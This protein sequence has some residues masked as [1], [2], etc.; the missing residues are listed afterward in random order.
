MSEVVTTNT[1]DEKLNELIEYMGSAVPSKLNELNSKI[2]SI[3]S[4]WKEATITGKEVQAQLLNSIKPQSGKVVI[5]GIEY[6]NFKALH[7]KLDEKVSQVS[8]ILD[9]KIDSVVNVSSDQAVGGVKTFSSPP[10]SATNPTQGNQVAN[11]AYVDEV[12][13]TKLN[14]STYNTDKATFATKSEL[15]SGLNAKANQATTYSKSETYTK[16]EVNN[17]V[18]ANANATVN[19]TGNQTIAG[20]K[21]FSVPLVSATNPTAN[22]QV[23]NKAYVD[24]VG[25]AKVALTKYNSEVLIPLT[26][27]LVWSV[28]TTQKSGASKHFNSIDL[29]INEALKYRQTPSKYIDLYLT[30]DITVPSQL[31]YYGVDLKHLRIQGGRSASNAGFKIIAGANLNANRSD[32]YIFYFER[33]HTPIFVGVTFKGNWVPN[34]TPRP[35]GMKAGAKADNGIRVSNGSYLQTSE[36]RFENL[37]NATLITYNSK[38][39]LYRSISSIENCNV[40]VFTHDN[41]NVIAHNTAILNTNIAVKS[42]TLARVLLYKGSISKC[43][44]GLEVRHGGNIATN[45]TTLALQTDATNKNTSDANVAYSAVTNHGII[46]KN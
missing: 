35:T 14:I 17:L 44:L 2:D 41:T 15:S 28:G 34:T 36:C 13:N 45:G 6:D 11:K 29:A 27:N 8:D 7:E 4:Y 26:A 31:Y 24:S 22:N 38:A 33:S 37:N 18:N 20:V 1:Q 16:T 25:N 40:G 42:H 43:S 23:A 3:S 9:A 46:F 21:T 39:C 30:S 10:V 32:R 12:G 19:L 5:N